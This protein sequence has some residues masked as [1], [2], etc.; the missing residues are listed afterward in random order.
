M[1]VIEYRVGQAGE[2]IRLVTSLL[3]PQLDPALALAMLYHE[4]WEI[5][6]VYDEFKT[7]QLGRSNSQHV[8]IR[9]HGPPAVVQESY[10]LVLAR[11]VV[12]T[13]MLAAVVRE[14]IDPDR[15]SFKS[16]GHR[17]PPFAGAGP[18]RPPPASPLL[19]EPSA[20]QNDPGTTATTRGTAQSAR[21]EA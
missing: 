9:A 3:D 18:C 21:R 8:A 10:G 11:R 7:H 13:A 20:R 19:F 2:L 5:E 6:L 4:R 16:P 17:A 14:G 1:R 15:L 12:R